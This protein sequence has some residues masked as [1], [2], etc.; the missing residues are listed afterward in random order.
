MLLQ[1]DRCADDR[2]S[3][4]SCAFVL[5]KKIL[6]KTLLLSSIAILAKA[7]NSLILLAEFIFKQIYYFTQLRG[8]WLTVKSS[9]WYNLSSVVICLS[10]CDKMYCG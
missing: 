1:R 8:F 7:W 2:L 6:I 9:P 3:V 5:T 4:N 10:V